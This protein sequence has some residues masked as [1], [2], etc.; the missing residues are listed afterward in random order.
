M[1]ADKSPASLEGVGSVLSVF[2]R[3]ASKAPGKEPG[4]QGPPQ[5]V[6]PSKT[7]NP[8]PRAWPGFKSL[9]AQ[10]LLDSLALWGFRLQTLRARDSALNPTVETGHTVTVPG[11]EEYDFLKRDYPQGREEEV[12]L[13]GVSKMEIITASTLRG[14]WKKYQDP[15]GK[16]LSTVQGMACWGGRSQD[17][18]VGSPLTVRRGFPVL[19]WEGATILGLRAV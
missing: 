2:A 19:L 8:W 16:V 1:Y 13:V 4:E 7:A 10:R 11:K 12:V 15:T 17:E 9:V 14:C 5:N 18:D 3:P 6:C